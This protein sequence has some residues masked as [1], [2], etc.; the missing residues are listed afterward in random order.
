[1]TSPTID[2]RDNPAEHRYEIHVDG[3]LAGFTVYEPAEGLLAFV[4]TEIDDAYAGQGLA[5]ILVTQTLD[6]V[7]ARGLAVLPF[8]PYVRGFIQKNRDYVDLVPEDQR[9]RFDLA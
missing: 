9:A 3:A 5:K 8:C 7:R 6:D 4:H 2:V 1:M